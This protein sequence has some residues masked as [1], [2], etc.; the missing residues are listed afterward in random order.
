MQISRALAQ[1]FQANKLIDHRHKS[2]I[3]PDLS[4]PYTCYSEL[5]SHGL[6][7]FR[8]LPNIALTPFHLHWLWIITPPN[9]LQRQI[10]LHFHD[11]VP[12]E[13]Y[14]P[15]PAPENSGPELVMSEHN[16]PRITY[17][18][19][20]I[21]MEISMAYEFMDPI[22]LYSHTIKLCHVSLHPDVNRADTEI[23]P[24]HLHRLCLS[25]LTVSG[26]R[27]SPS[28]AT[29]DSGDFTPHNIFFFFL[30]SC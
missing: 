27:S 3:R 28:F 22:E 11:S 26:L 29:Q 13:N 7:G 14:G 20:R 17:Q 1:L 15:P 6:L 16:L 19:V 4:D 10:P 9:Q 8:F 5:S 18:H 30:V 25:D 23:T 12:K 21:I 24:F 2:L